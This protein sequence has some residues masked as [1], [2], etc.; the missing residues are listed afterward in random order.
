[1]DEALVKALLELL[2]GLEESIKRAREELKGYV[3]HEVSWHVIRAPKPVPAEDRAVRWLERK[4]A[5]IKNKHPNL[6]Y[7]FLRNPEGLITALRY[8]PENEEVDEDVK[9]VAE[10]AFQK[11]ASRPV[12]SNSN[13]KGG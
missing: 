10:W 1:M 3:E 2:N 13:S 11:A 7:E 5:E 4:L 8:Q 9:A 12:A 6:R